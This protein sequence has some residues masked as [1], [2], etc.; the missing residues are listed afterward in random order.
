VHNHTTAL[1]LASFARAAQIPLQLV[2]L[3]QKQRIIRTSNTD[4]DTWRKRETLSQRDRKRDRK[5]KREREK[6]KKRGKDS[7]DA[8]V[9]HYMPT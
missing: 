3:I 6:D 9:E 8:D 5:K 2:E 7:I 1:A 4:I